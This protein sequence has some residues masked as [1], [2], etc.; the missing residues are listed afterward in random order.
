MD[1]PPAPALLDPWRTRALACLPGAHA[2]CPGDRSTCM[3][4]PDQPGVPPPG[5]PPLLLR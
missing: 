5:G 1:E 2:E 3:P 4:S